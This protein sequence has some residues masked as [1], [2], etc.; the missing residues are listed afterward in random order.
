MARPGLTRRLG[1]GGTAG[2][3]FSSSEG[4]GRCA[5]VSLVWVAGLFRSRIPR[6]TLNMVLLM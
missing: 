4:T 3:G 5:G 1:W 6:S 2:P